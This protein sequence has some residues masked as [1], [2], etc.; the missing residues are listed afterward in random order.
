MDRSEYINTDMWVQKTSENKTYDTFAD[1]YFKQYQKIGVNDVEAGDPAATATSY[2]DVPGNKVVVHTP[3][4][5]YASLDLTENNKHNQLVNKQ[6]N[7]IVM[8]ETFT[9][10]IPHNG[11]HN[12]DGALK[13][14]E[15]TFKG[16]A[17]QKP[18]SDSFAMKKQAK[19]D[20]GIV[21]KDTYYR[22]GTWIDL[23]A[24][25]ERFD[26][27][28]PTWEDEVW[29][30]KTTK[31]YTRVIA[32]NA[33][34]DGKV[35]SS[36]V[37]ANTDI[38]KYTATQDFVVKIIGKMYDIQIR[39]TDD[40]GWTNMKNVL[41]A[42]GFPI[43]QA[44]QNSVTGYR[45]GLKMGA[46]AYFDLKV[47]G[48]TGQTSKT[49]EAVP[50][51]YYVSKNG[52]EAQEVDLY[53]HRI[54][55]RFVSLTSNPVT[56]TERMSQ[57]YGV[58][59]FANYNENLGITRRV[60]GN[61][62][63]YTVDNSLGDTSKIILNAVT[64]IVA[65]RTSQ[66]LTRARWGKDIGNLPTDQDK[67]ISSIGRWYGEVKVPAS[68][69]VVTK[70]TPIADVKAG[71]GAL[72]NGYL[73]VAFESLITKAENGDQYL[74]YAKPDGN[75]QW[76]KEAYEDDIALPNGNVAWL[77]ASAK[78]YAMVI[79]ETDVRINNDYESTGTH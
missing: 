77:P 68:T 13:E 52:G 24:S 51:Y 57:N 21:Y 9:I 59:Y 23:E 56:I 72:K 70:G 17:G 66:E 6:E 42:S 58:K 67:I 2:I 33:I 38:S 61:T 47:D 45:Y 1:I 54:G 79:Y 34:D 3:V 49:I 55:E 39:A 19:F 25:Q 73:I 44:G 32:E 28:I 71:K 4:V 75:T 53:Y 30:G 46:K 18:S 20:F 8:G 48:G 64:R 27:M 35:N 26:F 65:Y 78:D 40:A 74:S 36:Q 50:K 7:A 60:T 14:D 41:T 62:V 37:N 29:N 22:A 12:W 76:Q 5:D 63:N 15:S 69:V 31:I 43:G 16:H 10:V 11:A